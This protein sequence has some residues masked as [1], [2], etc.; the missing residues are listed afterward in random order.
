MSFKARVESLPFATLR[1]DLYYSIPSSLRSFVQGQ[2]T[3]GIVE[4]FEI[5]HGALL[6]FDKLFGIPFNVQTIL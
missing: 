4:P 2:S 3:C 1:K 5:T 6:S